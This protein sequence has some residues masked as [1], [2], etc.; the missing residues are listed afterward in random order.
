MRRTPV[1]SSRSRVCTTPSTRCHPFEGHALPR[2]GE[3]RDV[4]PRKLVEH[5]RRMPCRLDAEHRAGN[6]ALL[7][8]DERRAVDAEVLLP[9]EGPLAPN[10]VGIGG[11][12]VRIR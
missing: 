6:L 2:P 8:D 1:T 10:T 11:L 4:L 9:G 5:A 7:V 12:V 3:L